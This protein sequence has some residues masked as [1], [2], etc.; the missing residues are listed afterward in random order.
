MQGAR[1][2]AKLIPTGQYGRLYCTSDRHARGR[3]FHIQV[4]PKGESAIP[5]GDNNLC[6]NKDAV[7]VYGIIGGNPGWTEW[8]GWLQQGKWQEDFRVLIESKRTEYAQKQLGE[9]KQKKDTHKK[10]EER[11]TEL[12]SS[13]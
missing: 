10:E 3:T 8:Y 5:N 2:Y 13:Y 4:L 7:E 12:L 6:I 9:E 11:I 1:E